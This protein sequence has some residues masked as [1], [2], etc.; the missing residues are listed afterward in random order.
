MKSSLGRI[1]SSIAIVWCQATLQLDG[2]KMLYYV[3]VHVPGTR[4]KGKEGWEGEGTK[5]R[6]GSG[7]RRSLQQQAQKQEAAPTSEQLVDPRKY[8]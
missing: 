4:R 1:A 2:Y 7:P 6:Q 8:M 5:G 3:A